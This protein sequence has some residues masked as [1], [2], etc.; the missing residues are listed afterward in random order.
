M[1]NI[2]PEEQKRI[3]EWQERTG[4]KKDRVPTVEERIAQNEAEIKANLA[5]LRRMVNSGCVWCDKGYVP[6]QSSV[7]DKM[8]HTGMR[9]IQDRVVCT[10]A[11]G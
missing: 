9:T 1:P 3:K 8:V 6:I 10:K 5:V 4:G 11:C 7:S 2:N